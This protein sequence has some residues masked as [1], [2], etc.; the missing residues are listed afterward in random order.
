[1]LSPA[2]RALD[3]T[4]TGV[5]CDASLRICFDS[6]GA[7]VAQTRLS[8][9]Y[10]AGRNL[11]RQIS[12]RPYGSEIVFS[13]GERCDLQRRTC[14]DNGSGNPTINTSLSRQLFGTGGGSWSNGT[15]GW[16][17]DN[18]RYN[19]EAS[20]LLSQRGRV[21]FNGDC[22]LRQRTSTNGSIAYVVELPDGRRYPFFN[23]QG[24]LVLRDSTGTWP[25]QSSISGNDVQFRW[26]DLQ[27][28]TRPRQPL[29]TNLYPF[30]NSNQF[31]N[32]P[33]PFPSNQN[34]T[35]SFLQNLFNSLFR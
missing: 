2:A 33:Y 15:S 9:G 16:S 22:A 1:M 11:E 7:S 23:R 32:N 25:A 19:R 6:T 8:F 31:P 17:G 34:P 18:Q 27:L 28:V 4:R 3:F 20:C 21:L 14:W 24:Q 29:T 30:P 13:S 5:V 26:N 10:Q 35:G 12:E